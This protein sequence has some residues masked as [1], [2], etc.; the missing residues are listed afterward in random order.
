MIDD[1]TGKA[2]TIERQK[3]YD[4]NGYTMYE[5]IT[6]GKISI[7]K[8]TEG[9]GSYYI[10]DGEYETVEGLLKQEEINYNPPET[11]LDDSGKPKQVPDDY[12]EDTAEHL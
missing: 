3:V 7:R 6:T 4:Y 9:G 8:D 11:I 5:D 1:I 2:A 12:S 10:G